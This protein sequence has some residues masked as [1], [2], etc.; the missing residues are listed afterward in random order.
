MTRQLR[1]TICILTDADSG[2][3]FHRCLDGVIRNVPQRD[4][5]IRLGFDTSPHNFY[6]ALGVLCPDGAAPQRRN[7]PG[8]IERF[9]WSGTLGIKCQAWHCPVALP[10]AR[11]ARL[12]YHDCSLD[13]EY[14]IA[15]DA[16]SCVEQGWWEALE[17]QLEQGVDY[18]G[19][20]VWHEYNPMQA[21]SDSGELMVFGSSF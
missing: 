15:L 7:L 12:L 8:G 6:H 3:C 2:E 1:A 18:V 16:T 5:E 9:S 21:G 14:V 4:I 20:L 11:M 13:S 10:R 19:R 17:R